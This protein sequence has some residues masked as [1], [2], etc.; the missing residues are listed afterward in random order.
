MISVKKFVFNDFQVNTFVVSDETEECL[1]IDPGCYSMHEK[2]ELKNYI[3]E[4]NLKPVKLINTH[5]HI[6]HIL[7]N[8][9]IKESFNIPVAAHRED[10]NYIEGV[11][12]QGQMFGYSVENP[13][14]IDEFL[15]D[16]DIVKFGKSELKVIHV[17]GHSKGSI[18]LYS[19]EQKFVI[20]GDVLFNG[21]IGRTDLL[22]G[23]YDT[24][25]KTIKNKLLTL[26][27][28]V[29]V[30]AGHGPSTTISYEIETNPF[31]S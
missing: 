21:G 25:I 19:E 3:R 4:N 6:D 24:L 13:G 26:P 9:F 7:G 27:G 5:G 15:E 11:S 17:P 29:T 31:L 1:I 16:D 30:Y 2:D 28:D 14:G 20:G 10:K 8:L 12:D 22:G 18:A 23:D